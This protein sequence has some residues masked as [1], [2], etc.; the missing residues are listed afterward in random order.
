MVAVAV[1]A[2]AGF[3]VQERRHT[4]PLVPLGIFRNRVILLC[5]L[6][7]AAGGMVWY[8]MLAFV[9]PYLQGVQGATPVMAGLVLAVTEAGWTTAS[10]TMGHT[11]MRVGLRPPAVIGASLVAIGFAAYRL[12][13]VA[14]GLWPP[15]LIDVEIG[16][17]LGGFLPLT[18]IAAQN[19][20]GWR[21]RGVVTGMSMFARTIG[22]SI[23]VAVAGVVFASGIEAAARSGTDPNLLL[24]AA[25]R[26]QIPP[27][28]VAALQTSLAHTLGDVFGV[29]VL[30]AVLA[31]VFLA[32]LPGRDQTVAYHGGA[33]AVRPQHV[34]DGLLDSAG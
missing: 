6:A 15:S 3:V 25:G 14:A 30:A 27:E 23:G 20:V 29:F 28:Q 33:H 16:L 22:G 21:Q 4:E 17:G 10:I 1:C 8:G 2:L 32:F 12:I 11:V 7:G 26:A 5:T 24:S 9:P 34:R 18:T 13:P 31:A 19:A